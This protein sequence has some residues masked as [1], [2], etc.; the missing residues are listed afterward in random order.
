MLAFILWVVAGSLLAL[1]VFLFVYAT[2]ELKK[3]TKRL[4][5][6]YRRA[7]SSFGLQVSK[8]GLGWVPADGHYQGR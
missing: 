5:D 8:P 6:S 4:Q 7:N 2:V 3:E 1:G